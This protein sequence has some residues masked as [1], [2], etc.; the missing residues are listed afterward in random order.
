MHRFLEPELRQPLGLAGAGAEAGTPEQALGLRL[1]ER[2]TVDGRHPTFSIGAKAPNPL[3]P[4]P[5]R[6]LGVDWAAPFG[7]RVAF[8]QAAV[9]TAFLGRS[10]LRPKKALEKEPLLP[11]SAR[12]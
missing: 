10:R 7:G 3:S 1:A 12:A 4:G 11:P 8:A 9:L 5:V 2:T 6:G